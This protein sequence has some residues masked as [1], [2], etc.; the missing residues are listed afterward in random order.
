VDKSNM[1]MKLKGMQ[2][3]LVPEGARIGS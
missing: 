2:K 3:T 1:S